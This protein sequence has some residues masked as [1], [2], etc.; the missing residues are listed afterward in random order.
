VAEYE[1][2]APKPAGWQVAVVVLRYFAAV[3]MG[4]WVAG[5]ID[6]ALSALMRGSPRAA[7]LVWPPETGPSHPRSPA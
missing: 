3:L 2:A 7:M 5:P 6:P 1:R 4:G